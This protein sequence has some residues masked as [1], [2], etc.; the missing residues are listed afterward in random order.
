MLLSR[1]ASE[2]C[3]GN[4]SFAC[5]LTSRG[6]ATVIHP[7][8]HQDQL[9]NRARSPNM[10]RSRLAGSAMEY[11]PHFVW[12]SHIVT[13]RL[14]RHR[15][16]SARLY[17]PDRWALAEAS[18]GPQGSLPPAAMGLQPAPILRA[19][20]FAQARGVLLKG[21]RLAHQPLDGDH[22]QVLLAEQDVKSPLG[23]T[24]LQHD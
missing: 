2:R 16:R 5:V 11:A 17:L 1:A 6:G 3:E 7:G 4:T 12:F 24:H 10:P 20:L 18:A 15:A 8:T 21:Q 13:A 14:T 23:G 22:L 19:G 9:P